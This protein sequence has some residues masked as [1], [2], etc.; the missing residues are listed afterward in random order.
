MTQITAYLMEKKLQ[1]TVPLVAYLD[2]GRLINT[3]IGHHAALKILKILK[4]KY[5]FD[6]VFR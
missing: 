2:L 4:K 1:P 5:L 3:C 6:H